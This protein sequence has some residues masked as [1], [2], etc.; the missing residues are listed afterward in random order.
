MYTLAIRAGKLLSRPYIPL[1]V[2]RNARQGF[3]ERSKFEAVRAHLPPPLQAVVTVAYYTGWRINSEL[4]PLEWRNV[5][6]QAGVLRLEP[7]TTKNR[8]GRTFKYAEIDELRTTIDALWAAHE[9]L[10]AQTPPILCPYVF[11]RRGQPIKMYRKA[12]AASVKAA[13]C[14]GRIPHDFRR[15]A[16][17][18]LTRA[19]VPET[20]A[21]KMTGHKTRAVFDRYDIT[22]ETDLADASRKLQE[23]T[24]TIAGTNAKSDA[25]ALKDRLLKSLVR[26]KLGNDPGGD[27][28]RGPLIKSQMLYH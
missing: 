6:R 27:R 18:N 10:K 23:L 15:T 5:D 21:M 22:D 26:K 13:A 16:V 14:P 20:V 24:G 19:G 3:F 1:L 11:H 12:W 28:T 2:E 8:E 25:E 7:N 17:R 9:A 4:L